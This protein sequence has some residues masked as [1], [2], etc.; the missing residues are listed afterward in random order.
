MDPDC[1]SAA[2]TVPRFVDLN[3]SEPSAAGSNIFIS[4]DDT[5]VDMQGF[6]QEDL[7]VLPFNLEPSPRWRPLL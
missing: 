5:D 7:R 1:N 2:L 4:V 3:S 6:C